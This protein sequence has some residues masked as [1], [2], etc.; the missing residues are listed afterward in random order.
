MKHPDSA[1][2]ARAIQFDRFRFKIFGCIWGLFGGCDR[3]IYISIFNFISEELIIPPEEGLPIE[4]CRMLSF[5]KSFITR[6]FLFSGKSSQEIP[7][8][9]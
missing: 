1:R 9:Q 7:P 4:D 6:S 5:S 8:F 2:F 3:T